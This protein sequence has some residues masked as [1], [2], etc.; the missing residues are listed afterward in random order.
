MTSNR[1]IMEE[2]LHSFVDQVLEPARQAEVQA[3]FETHADVA[4]RIAGY[5]QQREAL[6]AASAAV[7]DEPI[8]PHLNPRHIAEAR[9]SS[10]VP[11]RSA[12]AAVVL[13]AIGGGAGWTLHGLD[14]DPSSVAPNGIA[15]LAQEAAYTYDVYGPERLHPVEFKAADRAELV[16]WISNSLQRKISVPDLSGSGY[17]FMGG[18]VVATPHGP[19]GM[20]MYDDTHGVRLAMLVRLMATDK[21]TRMV[22]HRQGSVRGYAWSDQ[23]VG[24]SLVGPTSTDVLHPLADEI[25]RQFQEKA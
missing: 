17:R 13:L 5:V 2:D 7:A 3:Y 25:R 4:A 9:R 11:W 16:D 1:P 19:A 10:S 20:L 8:P 12:A 18:R 23:G 14:A 22:E 24:Y 21:N 15:S 6:R